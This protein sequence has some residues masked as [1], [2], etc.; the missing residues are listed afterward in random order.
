[1]RISNLGTL[2]K[3][4]K[5]LTAKSISSLPTNKNRM[6]T[7]VQTKIYGSMMRAEKWSYFTYTKKVATHLTMSTSVGAD[8]AFL[9]SCGSAVGEVA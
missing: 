3:F 4:S 9:N 6:F 2:V 1:M 7:E 8:K 5:Y